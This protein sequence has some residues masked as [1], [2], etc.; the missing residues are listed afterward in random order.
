MR[1]AV[2]DHF[3]GRSPRPGTDDQVH[4]VRRERLRPHDAVL[5]VMLL[6]DRGDDPRHA[7]AVA[8]HH[9][10]MLLAVLV[11][12]VRVE[13]DG[14]LRADLEHVTDLD[15]AVDRQRLAAPRARVAGARS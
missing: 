4:V 14:V 7:D 15:A 8:A 6:D 1:S 12:V 9:H 2:R 11:G 10:R 3:R 5:V 13:R